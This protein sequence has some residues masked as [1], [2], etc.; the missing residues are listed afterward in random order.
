MRDSLAVLRGQTLSLG[1]V[2]DRA[3]T[4]DLVA[5]DAGAVVDD[6]ARDEL[7]RALAKD[8][9]L[10]FVYRKA[11][12]LRDVADAGEEVADL[13]RR[14]TRR[15]EAQ[16]VG[17]AGVR[18]A[19]LRRD[20]GQARVEPPRDEVADGGARARALRQRPRAGGDE[21]HLAGVRDFAPRR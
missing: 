16:V 14:L 8:A 7:P 4:A 3:E 13:L 19:E 2:Q 6:D 18:P 1:A 20:A 5:R 9:R 12:V 17:V 10:R 21:E 15:G 11:L